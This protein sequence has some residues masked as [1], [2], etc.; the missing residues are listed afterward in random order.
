[1][2]LNLSY[3]LTERKQAVFCSSKISTLKKHQWKNASNI[4][5]WAF[6]ILVYINDICNAS[7][8]R[9]YVLF[10]GNTNFHVKDRA[11]G[12]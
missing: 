3:Y 11:V 12:R 10:A 5:F 9:S 8:F 6:I 1:M 7:Y 4:K 2:L